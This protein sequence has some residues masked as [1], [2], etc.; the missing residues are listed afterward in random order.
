LTFGPSIETAFATLL[1]REK[2]VLNRQISSSGSRI[3]D[4]GSLIPEQ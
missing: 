4:G 1:K 2:Q 3:N